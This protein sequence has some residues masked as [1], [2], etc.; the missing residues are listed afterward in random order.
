MQDLSSL[1][2]KGDPKRGIRQANHL[3][4]SVKSLFSH[5]N[6]CCFPDHPFR[7]PLWGTVISTTKQPYEAHWHYL[8]R[9]LLGRGRF[10][11]PR[12]LCGR[13]ARSARLCASHARR[14][15]VEALG[16][17]LEHEYGSAN[18]DV[19][20]RVAFALDVSKIMT[21]NGKCIAHLRHIYNQH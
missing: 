14:E 9:Q 19:L 8:H 17:Y 2:P 13:S 21:G 3:K 11:T 10:V 6:M 20:A 1:S 15:R 12:P 5:L 18:R 4:V 7:M 16:K